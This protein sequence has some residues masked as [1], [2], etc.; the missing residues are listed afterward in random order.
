MV[1]NTHLIDADIFFPR[2]PCDF[3]GDFRLEPEPVLLDG[4]ARGDRPFQDLVAGLHVGEVQISKYVRDQG[5]AVI[6]Q[7]VPEIEHAMP[8]R[9]DEP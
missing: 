8:L 9:A 7:A 4:D 5:K 1:R 6:P 2:Q 3:R